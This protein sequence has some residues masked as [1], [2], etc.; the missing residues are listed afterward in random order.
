M[1]REETEKWKAINQIS[2]SQKHSQAKWKVMIQQ[3]DVQN[4][5]QTQKKDPNTFLKERKEARKTYK[6]NRTI[7]HCKKELRVNI[8]NVEK[9]LNNFLAIEHRVEAQCFN[10]S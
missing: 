5:K 4:I 2:K 6:L 10:G 3:N 8:N 7:L 9:L 1:K